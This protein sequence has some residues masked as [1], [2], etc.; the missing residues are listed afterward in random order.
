MSQDCCQKVYDDF[1]GQKMARKQ[2]KHYLKKGVRKNSRPIINLL[3]KL[4]VN[5]HSLLD[6]GGGVGQITFELSKEGVDQV[7]HVDLS[8]SYL[9]TYLEEV[10][11]RNMKD[12]IQ[13]MLGDFVDL[14]EKVP[15]SDIVTLDKVICCYEDYEQLVDFSSAKARKWYAFTVPRDV[16]WVKAVQQIEVLF[17]KIKRDPFR[18]YVHPVDKIEDRLERA[19]FR[20]IDQQFRRE[21]M[22]CVFERQT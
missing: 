22:T 7:T 3:K 16:W 2:L 4:P 1:F 12:R 19:G 5:G 17:Q 8:S 9:N 20:K 14:H 18:P 11:K 10:E 15:A 6:I 21:W 13:T